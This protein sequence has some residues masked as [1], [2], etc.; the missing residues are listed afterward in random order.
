MRKLA[1]AAE[2]RSLDKA[3]IRAG[4]PGLVL[5][6][7]AGRGTYVAIRTQLASR[8]PISKAIVV[9][10]KGNNG[11]DGFV[12]GRFLLNAGIRVSAFLLGKTGDLIDD[13]AINA[14]AFVATGGNVSEITGDSG[15]RVLRKSL[16]TGDLTVDAIFGT[17]LNTPVTGIAEKVIRA[18]NES[19]C[20][21]CSV[22]IPSGISAD[23]GAELG[24]AVRADMTVTYGLEKPGHYL[25]PGRSRAGELYLEVIPIPGRMINA[26]KPS[27]ELIGPG[28]G[29]WSEALHRRE[30]NS[31]KGS[32]GHT[33]VLGGSH[34][35]SGAAVIA[36]RGAHAGGSGLV[37]V[38]IPGSLEPAVAKDMRETMT[39][40]LPENPSGGWQDSALS[41]VSRMLGGA[42]VLV[43]GPG[44]PPDQ[45]SQ[46]QFLELLSGIKSNIPV[47]I[48]ADGLNALTA[49]RKLPRLKDAVLTPHPG[50]AARLLGTSTAA[51]QSDRVAAVRELV[52]RYRCVVVLKG[53]GTLVNGPGRPVRINPTGSPAMAT[54]GMGDL[55]SGLIGGILASTGLDTFEAATAGVWIHGKAGDLAASGIGRPSVTATEVWKY[56]GKAAADAMKAS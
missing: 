31:H 51:I 50:E 54:G 13:A 37:T 19:R 12:I 38:A 56:T 49:A 55:L 26:F 40:L 42:H 8:N 17:G 11:G 1:T 43:A 4:V 21:V 18:I 39:L 36:A 25:E 33:I 53:A 48:D 2:M 44:M 24:I 30:A 27:F 47:V 20:R 6:E 32:F 3:A 10:G 46:R 52:R 41:R 5:M 7:N 29:T 22:D 9:C 45:G 15:I 34:G 16:T 14:K 28:K 23:T 35:K